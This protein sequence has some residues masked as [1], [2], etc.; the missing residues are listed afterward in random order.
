MSIR[1][2]LAGSLTF[3]ASR[4]RDQLSK[5]K[6]AQVNLR[7]SQSVDIQ[8]KIRSPII[9]TSEFMKGVKFSKIS[10]I[11]SKG[12]DGGLYMPTIVNTAFWLSSI[13]TINN[14]CSF[15]IDTFTNMDAL[16]SFL[17]DCHTSALGK[18]ITSK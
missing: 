18:P 14:S 10:A 13:F 7:L 6:I 12:A 15:G 4:F 9:V 3:A 1:I 16:M 11:A 5:S 2:D 17:T 8:F